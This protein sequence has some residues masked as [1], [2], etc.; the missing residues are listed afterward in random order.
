[1]K[2]WICYNCNDELLPGQPC[3]LIMSTEIAADGMPIPPSYAP[4]DDRFAMQ[5]Y[6]SDECILGQWN[7]RV[8]R[9]DVE[10]ISTWWVR[11]KKCLRK[12]H[13]Y[14]RWDRDECPGKAKENKHEHS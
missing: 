13:L 7:V 11:C 3:F 14:C 2:P 10:V 6:C 9:H 8:K 5:A 4:N 1:M 12:M